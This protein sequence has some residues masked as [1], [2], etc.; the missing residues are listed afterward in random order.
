[1]ETSSKAIGGWLILVAFGV[2]TRPFY[3]LFSLYPMY[4]EMFATEQWEILR[5]AGRMAYGPFFIPFIYSELII[6]ILFILAA[7]CLIYLFFSKSRHF[8]KYFITFMLLNLGFIL[9]DAWLGGI[10][11]EEPVF[12]PDT[13]QEI[14][15]IVIPSL[16]WIPYMLLSQ[17]VK[18]TFVAK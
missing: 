6:N 1:V 14:K 11:T 4:S 16:I 17:R 5:T 3:L 12:D 2:L 13:L 18:E 8:P 9:I 10:L 15:R 7:F